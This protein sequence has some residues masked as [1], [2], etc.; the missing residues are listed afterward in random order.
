MSVGQN[1]FLRIAGT[2]PVVAAAELGLQRAAELPFKARSG[3]GEH[4]LTNIV[5]SLWDPE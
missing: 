5:G 1:M 2:V 4:L 3:L